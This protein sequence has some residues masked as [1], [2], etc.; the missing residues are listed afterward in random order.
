M[1]RLRVLG[2]VAAVEAACLAYVTV[3]AFL[4]ASATGTRSLFLGVALGALGVVVGIQAAALLRQPTT[5]AMRNLSGCN[6]LLTLV[7]A[8]ALGSSSAPGNVVAGCV[9]LVAVGMV[10]ASV[11]TDRRHSGDALPVA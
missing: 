1:S 9:G 8:G 11:A 10:L 4:D 2:G 3:V 7:L 5:A 6:V